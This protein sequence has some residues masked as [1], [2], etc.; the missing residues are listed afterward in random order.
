VS[1]E[2]W[3]QF[4]YSWVAAAFLKAYLVE[5]SAGKFLPTNR[6]ETETLLRTLLLEKALYELSYELN[7]RPDWV[8]IPLEG[9]LRLLG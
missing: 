4:W 1:T 7:N 8:K 9:I 3:T 5:A 2:Q 6:A